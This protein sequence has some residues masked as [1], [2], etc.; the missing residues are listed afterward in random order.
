[1]KV[2]FFHNKK[3]WFALAVVCLATV[4]AYG[5]SFS[6]PF[7][8]DDSAQ[9]V[10]SS[11][12]KNFL[13]FP[14]LFSYEY[15]KLSPKRY[16]PLTVA[17]YFPQ[18]AFWRL[19]PWG[20][21]LFKL[22]LHLANVIL[23][24]FYLRLL[25]ISFG[26]GLT[27]AALFA[28]HPAQTESVACISFLD[29]PLMFFWFMLTLIAAARSLPGKK[30]RGWYRLS[31][32]FYLFA[33]ASMES[34]F[35]LP[36]W[37]FF[38][39]LLFHFPGRSR[40][41]SF[42]SGYLSVAVFWALIRFFIMNRVGPAPDS[43]P[44]S[45]GGG[46][47]ILST[48]LHYLKVS[49]FPFNLCLDYVTPLS[50]GPFH[51]SRPPLFLFAGAAAAFIL[52]GM[53]KSRR[54][55]MGWGIFFICLLPFSNLIRTPHLVSDRYLYLP[56]AGFSLAA[57]VLMIK[58]ASSARSAAARRLFT[59]S[60]TV[61]LFSWGMLSRERNRTWRDPRFLWKDVLD[62]SPSSVTAL[63]NLGS[64]NL[65]ADDLKGAEE[66]FRKALA[67]ARSDRKR[68]AVSINLAEVLWKQEK[69]KEALENLE[70][71][72]RLYPWEPRIFYTRGHMYYQAGEPD[73]AM[74]DYGKA[75]DLDPYH[76]LTY[77]YLSELFASQGRWK[78][79]EDFARRAV[80][81]NPD[82]ALGYDHLGIILA[83][84]GREELAKKYWRKA[85]ELDP[86]LESA[87]KNL[88]ASESK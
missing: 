86:D 64:V 3:E 22:L 5:N 40:R 50:G 70:E 35:V 19:N 54:L 49:F 52:A 39:S 77:D 67:I 10:E 11:F 83:N 27:A 55:L 18:Y 23:L 37:L 74:R 51:L 36:F 48:L 80:A 76:Y 71:A 1:M 82:F 47:M 41:V 44:L 73:S 16:R 56:L 85:L 15:F 17:F 34:A 57:A 24:Y 32:L 38:Q 20:Y 31:L 60:L 68:A 7:V 62:Y 13:F 9:I 63:N 4:I 2:N 29:G 43:V 53:V 14:A 21:H 25:K 59:V 78:E 84:R 88:A 45:A 79:A 81:L 30:G 58:T 28:L 65:E 12:I 66:C 69:R 6:V 33:L 8:Y 42:W 87:R 46:I 72:G 61:I 75:L 26:I